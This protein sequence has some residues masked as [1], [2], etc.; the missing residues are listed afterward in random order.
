MR[1]QIIATVGPATSAPEMLEQLALEG[2]DIMRNNFAHCQ[3]DEYKER[4][5]QIQAI[6]KKHGLDIKVQADLRGPSIRLGENIPKEGMEVKSGD[7]L[8]FVTAPCNDKKDGELIVT[9]PYLHADVSVGD[10]LLIESGMLELEIIEVGKDSHKFKAK[11]KLGGIIFPR[12]AL[13][14]PNTKLTTSSLTDKD[15]KDLDFVLSVGVDW[16]A[17]SFVSSADDVNRV[18]KVIGDRPIKIMS[19]IEGKM[20]LANLDEII[21]A[22]DAIIVARGDLGVETPFEELP[23]V[24]KQMIKKCQQHLKPAIVATQ[25]LKNMMKSPYPTRAEISDIANAVFDGA[26]MVWLSDETTVGEYPIEAV[27]VM[28]KV[29]DRISDYNRSCIIW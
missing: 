17:I 16:V 1:T 4:Y 8:T 6:N 11:V 19:K 9:D 27:K 29:I 22:S 13:N 3:Y 14:L 20:G 24:Q 7:I 15:M 18:R 10:Q 5:A 12:K 28:R 25:M 23:I 21:D 26:H 2:V